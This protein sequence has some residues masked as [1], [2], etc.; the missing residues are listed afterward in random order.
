MRYVSLVLQSCFN[1]LPR[2]PGNPRS[3]PD[4]SRIAG[5]PAGRTDARG[6]GLTPWSGVIQKENMMKS[7]P[8][9]NART[10]RRVALTI[11]GTVLCLASSFGLL[12]SSAQ[13]QDFSLSASPT[14]LTL[15]QGATVTTTVTVNQMSMFMGPVSFTVSGLPGGVTY[16]IPSTSTSTTL[17]LI[18]TN[19]AALTTGATITITGTDTSGSATTT[20]SLDVVMNP[21]PFIDSVSPLT[22]APASGGFTLN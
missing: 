20:V 19:A 21:V 2:A 16:T 6:A 5:E 4:A 22:V 12:T 15:P 14:S 3:V 10:T 13:A 18:A 9:T 1:T 8:R 11:L 17:T 7:Q